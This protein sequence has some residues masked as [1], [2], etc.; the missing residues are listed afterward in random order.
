MA[1]VLFFCVLFFTW[2]H[3]HVAPILND[4]ELESGK[5]A[6]DNKQRYQ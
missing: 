2:I 6:Y 3:F 5:L 4:N 1:Y